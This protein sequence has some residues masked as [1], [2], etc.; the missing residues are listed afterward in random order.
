MKSYVKP[1][2]QVNTINSESIITLSGTGTQTLNIN[3]SKKFSELNLN[4]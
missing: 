2:I 1:E 3:K 4:Q